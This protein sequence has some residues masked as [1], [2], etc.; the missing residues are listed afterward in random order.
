[1]ATYFPLKK[2]GVTN[3]M[4]LE[5]IKD[6]RLFAAFGSLDLENNFAQGLK[7]LSELAQADSIV[8]IKLYPGYQNIILSDPKFAPIFQLAEK[9][10]LPVACHLG[11]LHHCCPKNQREIHNYRCQQNSCLLDKRGDLSHPN[12]LGLVAVNFPKVNFIACHLA[13][14]FFAELRSIMIKCPNIYTDIS[15]QFL[16]ETD[17][18]TP[19]YQQIVVAEIKEFLKLE[20]G[21]DRILFG[22]DFPVQSYQSTLDL[23]EALGIRPSLTK[24]LFFENATKLLNL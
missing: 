10:N 24:K 8:G 5:R 18:D 1:M 14:P 6:D 19:V 17:E 9:Y 22:T 15:G 11:E 16:S 23:V 3:E 4:L 13:N 12:Q 20:S 21:P 2:S 7:E